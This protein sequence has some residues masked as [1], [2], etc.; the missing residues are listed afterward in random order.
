MTLKDEA[1]I[2]SLRAQLAAA[3]K[4]RDEARKFHSDEYRNRVE[5][6]SELTSLRASADALRRLEEWLRVDSSTRTAILQID[7]NG[8]RCCMYTTRKG[9]PF[10]DRSG[11]TLAAAIVAA[12]VKAREAK[13]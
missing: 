12:I 10:H 2:A 3:E 1:E 5:L 7:S 13:A 11:P 9:E 8:A 6:T 4:E